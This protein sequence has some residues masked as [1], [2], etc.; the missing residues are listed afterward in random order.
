MKGSGASPPLVCWLP[1]PCPRN[2]VSDP[3]VLVPSL[4]QA[5]KWGLQEATLRASDDS[6]ASNILLQLLR[7]NPASV[8]M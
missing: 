8:L 2:G 7:N 6:P 5:G 3:H 4:V 1:L